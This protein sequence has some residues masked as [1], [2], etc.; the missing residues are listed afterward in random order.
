MMD[1]NRP[2][3]VISIRP[4]K[5]IDNDDKPVEVIGVGYFDEIMQFLVIAEEDDEIWP[6]F[7]EQVFR[8]PARP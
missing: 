2:K 4:F 1:D 3:S 5:A 6:T 8:I 7:R